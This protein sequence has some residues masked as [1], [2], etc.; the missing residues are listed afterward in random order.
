MVKSIAQEA[1]LTLPIR[2]KGKNLFSRLYEYDPAMV[3][4]VMARQFGVPSTAAEPVDC[5]DLPEIPQ[6][7]PTL[8]A[9][10]S[11]RAVF[12]AV[13]KASEGLDVMYPSDIGCYT[14]GFLPPLSMG[15]FVVCMGASSGASGGFSKVTD[16]KVVAFIGD[17]T[18]FHSGMTGLLNAVFN[19]HDYT[20]IILDN[21]T[22][23]MTG[24]QP[25]P[26]VDMQELNMDGYNSVDVE[27]VVRGL[28]VQH[29]ANVRPYNLKKSTATIREAIEF[30]GVSV[31]I[32]KEKC[33]LY[34]KSLRQLRG[35]AFTISDKCK[36][37]KNCIQEL[38]C[39]AFYLR[40]GS[41]NIDPDL[42]AGCSICAQICPEKA[43]VPLK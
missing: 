15:D 3:R 41:V 12:Y 13:K 6:R 25:N 20:L 5:S 42:C 30:K 7:P 26:G 36:G 27:K 22:T 16:K 33:T 9:G 21:R 1:G 14:L 17:S 11:H 31:V 37:H 24:H 19:N 38:A 29:V 39:P 8:C 32:A 18:F 34:A 40:D 35:K 2:G 28:G 4:Q 23:A 10:C 43:I